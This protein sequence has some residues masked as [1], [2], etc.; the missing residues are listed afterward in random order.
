[1]E[2]SSTKRRG[3]S[4][5]AG[6]LG[7]MRRVAG[8]PFF[9]RAFDRLMIITTE[10]PGAR[11]LSVRRGSGRMETKEKKDG[12]ARRQASGLESIEKMLGLMALRKKK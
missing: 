6:V 5:S 4:F 11:V 1:M 2:G 9:E 10:L 12:K 3:K 7:N 8:T